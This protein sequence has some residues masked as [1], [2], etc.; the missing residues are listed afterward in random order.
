MLNFC[1]DE[2]VYAE[3]IEKF[4]N[5][6]STDEWYVSELIVRCTN[7]LKPEDSFAEIENLIPLIINEDEWDILLNHF[8]YLL[9]LARISETSEIPQAFKDNQK[10]IVD[11]IK[12]L[13]LQK[14]SEIKQVFNWYRLEI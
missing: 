14:H 1:R 9:S 3:E 5:E 11:K 4:R 7:G 12:S 8:Q 2:I 10:S 6:G 13:D